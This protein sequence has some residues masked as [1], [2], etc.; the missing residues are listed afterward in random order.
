MNPVN[1]IRRFIC[2]PA[3]AGSVSGAFCFSGSDPVVGT[4]GWP[5]FNSAR[6]HPSSVPGFTISYPPLFRPADG[7]RP[8][9]LSDGEF[10]QNFHFT[11]GTTLSNAVMEISRSTMTQYQQELMDKVDINAY[12]KVMS[13][14]P[15][16]SP[17]YTIDE[18]MPFVRNG[19]K[20]V[21]MFL[22]ET[23]DTDEVGDQC[24]FGIM[25]NLFVW[26]SL[27]VFSCFSCYPSGRSGTAATRRGTTP[28]SRSSA[29]PRSTRS[30]SA[31]RP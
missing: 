26:N 7:Y 11:D 25:R 1:I 6:S 10:V 14:A 27:F 19:H 17:D 28:S 5:V 13:I 30:S 21:D 23:K 8:L 9:R 16:V 12:A 4:E 3:F 15:M 18:T 20:G 31:S 22:T 29:C 24:L 2:A